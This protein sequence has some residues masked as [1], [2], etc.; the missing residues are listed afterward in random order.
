MRPHFCAR[1][2]LTTFSSRSPNRDVN[3]GYIFWGFLNK[4]RKAGGLLCEQGRPL[5][6]RSFT[7]EVRRGAASGG[8]DRCAL[9]CCMNAVDE[10][11][12]VLDKWRQ[13]RDLKAA[14]SVVLPAAALKDSMGDEGIAE[15]ERNFTFPP[16]HCEVG[17]CKSL[18]TADGLLWASARQEDKP[19]LVAR[20]PRLYG[21]RQFLVR[22]CDEPPCGSCS[23]DGVA[24]SVQLVAI[25]QRP[26]P[27]HRS[28][29]PMK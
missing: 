14:I 12:G 25:G 28:L 20:V 16:A 27:L 26:L 11:S 18:L 5:S 29:V 21:F 8:D 23:C 15:A 10:G 3:G 22:H 13:D 24:F 2:G 4:N 17:E 19:H 6:G 1:W 9:K 7:L